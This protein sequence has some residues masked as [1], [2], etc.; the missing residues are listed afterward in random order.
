MKRFS[1]VFASGL[2]VVLA[3]GISAFFS[4]C[5]LLDSA[6]GITISV[7]TQEFDFDLNADSIRG[8]LQQAI[9]D[10]LQGGVSVDLTGE[11]EI[12]QQV[13]DAQNNCVDVPTIKQSF[14]F[15]LPAQ[16]IDLSD[17]DELKKYVEAGKVTDVTIKFVNFEI[18]SNNLNF[19]LPEAELF[20]DALG[21]SQITD[22]SDKIAVLPSIQAGSTSGVDV[23]F[24][25]DGRQIM[26]GYLLG[27]KFAMLG[28]STVS[29]DTAV[30]RTIPKGRMIGKVK[31]GL[32]FTVDPL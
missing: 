19:D 21:A 31:I 18:Q 1:T 13:C 2:A 32:S 25:N 26:S 29:V 16:Q 20:M 6:G 9:N 4:G 10:E 24:T 17:Q 28:R 12:P 15:D 8:E 3:V 7:P 22:S 27:F 5:G 14:T 30:T 23:Q 11:D